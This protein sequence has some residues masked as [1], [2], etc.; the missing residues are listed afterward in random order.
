MNTE[1]QSHCSYSTQFVSS[2]AFQ[3]VNQPFLKQPGPWQFLQDI[4]FRPVPS[5][6]TRTTKLTG[7]CWTG[8]VHIYIYNQIL[9]VTTNVCFLYVLVSKLEI[10][11]QTA[12]MLRLFYQKEKL[13]RQFAGQC[14]RVLFFPQKAGVC[15]L[16]LPQKPKLQSFLIQNDLWK[17]KIKSKPRKVVSLEKILSNFTSSLKPESNKASQNYCLYK[18]CNRQNSLT[19]SNALTKQNQL[20]IIEIS[21]L[22]IASA[23]TRS[24]LTHPLLFSLQQPIQKTPIQNNPSL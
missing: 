20:F 9:D 10:R 2:H 22:S 13:R 19:T 8:K 4:Y 7:S 16:G 18:N 24:T 3:L 21:K 12:R 5:A 23:N 15:F 17:R 1:L 11:W 6:S 14:F